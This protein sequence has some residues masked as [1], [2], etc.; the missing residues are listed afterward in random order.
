MSSSSEN[1]VAFIG[2]GVMGYPMAKNLLSGLGAEKTLLVCDVSTSVID[3]FLN[4]TKGQGTVEVVANGFEATKVADTVITMLP[5]SDAVKSVYLDP[6]TGILAGALAAATGSGSLVSKLIMECGTIETDTILTVAKA[7][8]EVSDSKLDGT[9]TFVDAP[10]SG[11]PMGAEAGTLT[12]M[13]GCLPHVSNTV[14]PV[15]KSYLKHMGKEKEIFLCGD[16]GAGTAFKVI[17]NYL[18][19]ITSLAASE[20][21]NIGTKAGLDVKLLTDVINASGGQ[22]WVTSKSNPVPG[23]QENVPSSRN[24]DGGFRI[25]LCAKVLGMGSKL[26]KSVGARTILDGPTLEAFREAMADERYRGRDAR[27]VYKWLNESEG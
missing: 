20:A 4:E 23:V 10:V 25:E 3:R 9:L 5:G 12:F 17:N 6:E 24:Y 18:S 7:T 21:L 22:C 16:V 13:V 8:R 26:A 15:V 11:G 19:A 2:L 14:F 27:V 1:K